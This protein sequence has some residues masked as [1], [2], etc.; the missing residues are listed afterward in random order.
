MSPSCNEVVLKKE[1]LNSSSQ[2][3]FYRLAG[4]VDDGLAFHVEARIQNHFAPGGSPDC[5][6]QRME[7]AIISCRD[8]L[9]AR[10]PID[11][12]NGR[13]RRTMLLA[14]VHDHD[15]VRQFRTGFDVE[16]G[17]RLLGRH[18]RGERTERLALFH[19]GVDSIAHF[20]MPWIG[21]DAAVSERARTKLHPP[22]VPRDDASAR[23]PIGSFGTCH[24]RTGKMFDVDVMC[25]FGECSSDFIMVG[26]RSQEWHRQTPIANAV[27]R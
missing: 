18:S 24:L 26:S 2:E 1:T 22:A 27:V 16:P 7:V 25:L 20:R 5:L 12:S 6:Q 11:M 10:T 19:H 15:H 23:N 14:D 13:Q 8:G 21:K 4:S 3:C 9:N 17:M